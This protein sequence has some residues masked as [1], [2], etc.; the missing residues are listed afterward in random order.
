MATKT[1]NIFKTDFDIPESFVRDTR[2]GYS[3]HLLI[4][5]LT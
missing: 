1:L 3:R 4:T 5:H 2:L